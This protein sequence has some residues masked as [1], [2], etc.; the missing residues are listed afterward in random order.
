MILKDALMQQADKDW[1]GTKWFAALNPNHS[2][3]H[4]A[5]TL[6]NLVAQGRLQRRPTNKGG[7]N[8]Y[9]YRIPCDRPFYDEGES[10]PVETTAKTPLPKGCD[11]LS[12]NARTWYTASEVPD[13]AKYARVCKKK[14]G[15][16]VVHE[17]LRRMRPQDVTTNTQN[18]WLP[19]TAA[20]V[21]TAGREKWY[22]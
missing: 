6:G 9:Q 5:T 12:N 14:P 22:G 15:G 3:S 21:E 20:H 2:S 17:Y 8:R 1:H 10:E 16:K 13:K 7:R 4:I 11:A 18:Q 19:V